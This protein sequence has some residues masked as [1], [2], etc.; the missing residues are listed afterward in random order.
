MCV[1]RRRLSFI[2]S[3]RHEMCCRR[4]DAFDDDGWRLNKKKSSFFF[5]IKK[6]NMWKK[7]K[8]FG[9]RLSTTISH[10]THEK[11]CVW[12]LEEC[13]MSHN[14]RS[15]LLFIICETPYNTHI[16]HCKETTIFFSLHFMPK[17]SYNFCLLCSRDVVGESRICHS[18]IAQLWDD[19]CVQYALLSLSPLLR[20][21][22]PCFSI[23]FKHT[24]RSRRRRNGGWER[25]KYQNF[26]VTVKLIFFYLLRRRSRRSENMLASALDGINIK[27]K[28]SNLDGMWFAADYIFFS[29]GRRG[30]TFL[31][32]SLSLSRSNHHF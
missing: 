30:E 24:A 17:W 2:F 27:K 16:S 1:S 7:I 23:E 6:S 26:C 22:L 15:S 19:S 4:R 8:K 18:R 11:K 21:P 10:G 25:E 9:K 31:H 12:S 13:Q 29:S 32:F 20:A 5:F 3:C 14:S 28:S